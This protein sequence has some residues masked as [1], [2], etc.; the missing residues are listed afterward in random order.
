MHFFKTCWRLVFDSKYT[1]NRFRHYKSRINPYFCLVDLCSSIPSEDLFLIILSS[2]LKRSVNVKRFSLSRTNGTI[3]VKKLNKTISAIIQNNHLSIKRKLPEKSTQGTFLRFKIFLAIFNFYTWERRRMYSFIR[4]T[5]Q[6]SEIL[7]TKTENRL[8]EKTNVLRFF[9]S[10][11]NKE[12][13]CLFFFSDFAIASAFSV[14][15][16][17]LPFSATD[18]PQRIIVRHKRQSDKLFFSNLK[19]VVGFGLF[20]KV[21]VKNL[22]RLKCV[23]QIY[24]EIKHKCSCAFTICSTELQSLQIKVENLFYIFTYV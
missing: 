12:V 9:S 1:T 20:Q 2:T 17:V 8:T 6:I 22:V 24:C 23:R 14:Q 5:K 3:K 19:K 10:E 13:K 21:F 11:Q 18:N 7:K 16:S 4:I 15:R